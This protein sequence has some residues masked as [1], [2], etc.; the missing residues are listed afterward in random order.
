MLSNLPPRKPE[1]EVHNK[2]P[3]ALRQSLDAAFRS[4]R[5]RPRACAAS[6][7]SPDCTSPRFAVGYGHH[8]RS[9]GRLHGGQPMS[10]ELLDLQADLNERAAILEYDNGLTRGEAE[11]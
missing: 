3:T 5:A 2:L 11:A 9:R 4:G 8:D 1:H 7:R 6:C 10:R